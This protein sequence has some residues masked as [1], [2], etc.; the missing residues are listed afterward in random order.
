MLFEQL[1]YRESISDIFNCLLAHKN[2]AYHLGIK[3]PVAVLNF[4]SMDERNETII[5]NYFIKG[6][7]NAIVENINGRIKRYMMISKDTKDR[8]F[9]FL[10]L[11]RF[12]PGTSK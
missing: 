4:K 5:R 12:S 6:D 8:D 9:F 7:T 3:K 2:K 11:S 10:R 1:T